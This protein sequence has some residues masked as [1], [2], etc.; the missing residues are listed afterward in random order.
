MDAVF[1]LADRI[2]VLVYGRVIASG[3]PEAIRANAEVRAG[4]SGRAARRRRS[5]LTRRCSQL[6]DVETALRPRARCCSASRCDRGGRDGHADG[7]QR[8]GQ[9]HDRALDHGADAGDGRLDPLRRR[10]DPRAARPISIAQLGIGLVPEGRQVFPNL[11]VRENLVA[12]AA[13]RGEAAEPWTLDKRL[14]A[15]PAARRARAAAW[16]TSSPAASSRCWRSAAR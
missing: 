7:P 11:T 5:W 6:T 9:D 8:H 13:N 3:A 16:A 14:R 15:V 1:A 2:T 10:G 4:L 12:T